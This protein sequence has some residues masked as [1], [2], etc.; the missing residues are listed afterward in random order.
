M[1]LYQID[2]IKDKTRLLKT[3]NVDSGGISIISDKMELF[4]FYIK[5]L[6]TPAINIL[7]QDALSIGAELAVPCGVI[8][9]EKA[10]YDCILV[11]TI[12]HIKILAKKELSQPFGLKMVAK[13]LKEYLDLKSFSIKIMGVINANDDSFYSGSRFVNDGA[14]VKIREMIDDG[15]DIIDIGGVSS[16]P[17]AKVVS[18]KEELKRIKPI[19]DVIKADKLYRDVLFSIDSYDEEVVRYA[20][21]SGFGIINDITGGI[22]DNIIRLAIEY[23]A[24]LSIMHKKGTPQNMQDNPQYEDVIVEVDRFFRDRLDRCFELGLDREDIILDIGIGFGKTLNHNMSLIKNLSHFRRFGCELLIGVSRKSM[25]DM[26]TPSKPEDRLAGTLALHLEAVRNGA[27]MLRVHDV[28]EH[29]QA[30]KVQKAL[31]F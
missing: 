18:G 27:S 8:L 15:A 30:L 22:N 26:I 10:Y 21:Q 31:S 2:N 11:G 3:L 9:C 25:I 1:D 13:K 17:N 12:K 14:I 29:F 6:K 5:D 4:T 28:K 23:K 19:C 16:R 7:K 20:L 24:K